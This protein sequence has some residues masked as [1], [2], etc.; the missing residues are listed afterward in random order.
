MAIRGGFGRINYNY[1]ERYFIEFNGRYDAT[2]RFLKNVRY[3]F[4]PG[5]S[6]AWV[7][8]NEPFW[9]EVKPYM[10]HLKFRLS[11][12]QLGNQNIGNYYPFY[13]SLGTTT[14]TNSHY[15]FS[16]GKDVYVSQAGLVDPSLTWETTTS[17]NAGVDMS[18]LS[19]RLNFSFDW[20]RRDV[21]D[22]AA[23]SDIKPGVLGAEP[24]TSNSAAVRTEGFELS[25]E[26]KD[27]VGPFFYSIK[28]ILSD[29]ESTVLEYPNANKIR[30]TLYKGKKIGE[31][32]G[33]ETVGLFQSDEE[34]LTAPDQSDLY[35]RWQP[36]DCRYADLN[37]NGKIDWG[38]NTVDNLV[39]AV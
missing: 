15:L 25:L 10:N 16:T 14:S 28:G 6:G 26:W 24:P 31:I 19:S 18:F 38:D 9:T 11:Y 23:P 7:P 27:R 34:I 36:G 39:Q 37:G 1:K 22:I 8:S 13:P 21:T 29:Y 33:Y 30:W 5:V 17:L 3:K 20:Y 35:S 12:G 2:S 32:W 4:Y